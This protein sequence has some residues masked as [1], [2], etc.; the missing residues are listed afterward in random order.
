MMAKERVMILVVGL[1]LSGFC[2]NLIVS[3][4]TTRCHPV[5]VDPKSDNVA[6]KWVVCDYR[7]PPYA[8]RWVPWA[9]LLS[10]AALGDRVLVLKKTGAVVGKLM[11]DDYDL[12]SLDHLVGTQSSGKMVISDENA[13]IIWED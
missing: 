9:G 7:V 11:L 12:V 13:A 10:F 5:A 2:G 4:L 6:D 1:I 3:A 8:L